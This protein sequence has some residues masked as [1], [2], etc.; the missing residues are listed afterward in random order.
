MLHTRFSRNG[1]TGT[2]LADA[3]QQPV[4]INLFCKSLVTGLVGSTVYLRE[5]VFTPDLLSEDRRCSEE[6]SLCGVQST[7][8]TLTFTRKDVERSGASG[9]VVEA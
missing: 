6:L 9:S 2:N 1:H 3:P 4:S 8:T 7:E 5:A